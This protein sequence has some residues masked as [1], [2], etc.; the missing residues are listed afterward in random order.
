[1]NK[2]L[3]IIPLAGVLML[4]CAGKDLGASGGKLAPCPS[5]P[6]C[7]STQAEKDS[8]KMA[9]I[10][11]SG[12]AK[13]ALEKLSSVIGDMPRAKV[14]EK[15]DEYIHAVFSSRVFRFK[16][17][18]EFVISDEE[19]LIHFRSAS[20]LGYSDFGVNRKRMEEIQKKFAA[21]E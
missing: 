15:T 9:P 17:D 3:L 12:E 19:K 8:Q 5:S 20:R 2:T 14:L 18:V 10:A 13:E 7:V 4:G 1:M 16:D 11:Y 21:S 6:N